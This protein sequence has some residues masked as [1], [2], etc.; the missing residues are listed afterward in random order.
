MPW[1]AAVYTTLFFSVDPGESE[2]GPLRRRWRRL[3]FAKAEAVGDA[4]T[5][6]RSGDWSTRT[7]NTFGP[8]LRLE[9]AIPFVE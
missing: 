5:V 2:S 9:R 7:L 1:R 6:F 4:W 8:W 3:F